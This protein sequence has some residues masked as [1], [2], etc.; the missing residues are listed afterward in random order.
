[1]NAPQIVTQ[2]P[3]G[4]VDYGPRAGVNYVIRTALSDNP[5]TAAMELWD[6]LT[7]NFEDDFQEYQRSTVSRPDDGFQY[8]QV[9]VFTTWG[10]GHRSVTR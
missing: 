4:D 3:F 5:D 1:M 9:I 6:Y 7:S 10:D 2:L 8:V